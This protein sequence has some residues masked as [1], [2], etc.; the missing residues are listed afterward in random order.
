MEMAAS[1]TGSRN[2]SPSLPEEAKT[3]EAVRLKE[4]QDQ[5][6]SSACSVS[7]DKTVTSGDE[8]GADQACD[9]DVYVSC[10]GSRTSGSREGSVNSGGVVTEAMLQEEQ[11]LLEKDSTKTRREMPGDV[12]SVQLIRVDTSR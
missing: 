10:G 8:N 6:D 5:P 11:R 4:V 9:Q 3:F 7:A 1:I 2:P 12:S